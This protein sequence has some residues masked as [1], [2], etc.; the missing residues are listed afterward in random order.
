MYQNCAAFFSPSFPSHVQCK[1]TSLLCV[2]L[3]LYKCWCYTN[4]KAFDMHT[5][6]ML[7]VWRKNGWI[8]SLHHKT[9]QYKVQNVKKICSDF[10]SSTKTFVSQKIVTNQVLHRSCIKNCKLS[11]KQFTFTE[12]F[13]FFSF[14]FFF[15]VF[16]YC[17]SFV[18]KNLHFNW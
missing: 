11:Y 1:I 3:V 7:N 8:N 12:V 9:S 15:Q 10:N 13:F 4:D 5:I 14:S 6:C 17:P 18:R 2:V 16:V